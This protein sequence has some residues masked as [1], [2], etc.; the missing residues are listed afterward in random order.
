MFGNA[1]AIFSIRE[2]MRIYPEQWVAIAIKET[3]TDGFASAGV[4]IV[5]NSDEKFVW[6][7]VKLGEEDDPIYVFHTGS[8]PKTLAVA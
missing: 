1:T 6:S 3:D 5:H 2:I 4:V 7:A 8:R